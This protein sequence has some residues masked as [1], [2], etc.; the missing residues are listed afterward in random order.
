M[1]SEHTQSQQMLAATEDKQSEYTHIDIAD[2]QH[3][4]S[5]HTHRHS[6][7]TVQVYTHIDIA[8]TQSELTSSKRLIEQTH[9]VT[10][11]TCSPQTQ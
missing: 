10:A 1:Q 8:N 6:R 7:H 3:T 9:T 11:N 2:T 4:H 5:I